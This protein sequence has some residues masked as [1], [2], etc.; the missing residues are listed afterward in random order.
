MSKARIHLVPSKFED[1]SSQIV[2]IILYFNNAASGMDS[3]VDLHIAVIEVAKTTK[4]LF[5]VAD[6]TKCAK[7]EAFG[8]FAALHVS[9]KMFRFKDIPNMTIMTCLSSVLGERAAEF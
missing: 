4:A 9:R 8:G 7:C 3:L 1:R 5:C 6:P 2:E